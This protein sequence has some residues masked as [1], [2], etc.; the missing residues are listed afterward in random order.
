MER[1]TRGECICGAFF[2]CFKYA[3][4]PNCK[5]YNRVCVR[6]RVRACVPA[7]VRVCGAYVWSVRA[8]VYVCIL[9]MH[10]NYAC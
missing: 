5:N 9:I 8:R 1:F 3:F 6:A 10:V 4:D 7:C 2:V